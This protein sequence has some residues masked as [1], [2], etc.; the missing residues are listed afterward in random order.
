MLLALRSR[1]IVQKK[2]LQVLSFALNLLYNP[3]FNNQEAIMLYPLT[4]EDD[5]IPAAP[6]KPDHI[7]HVFQVQD[8]DEWE[9]ENYV[10]DDDVA[11]FQHH[12]VYYE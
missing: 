10:D 1:A 2:I 3:N 7:C 6:V 11:E 9:T 4:P 5:V 12:D 8:A